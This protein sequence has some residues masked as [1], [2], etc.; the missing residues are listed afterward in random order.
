M[1]EQELKEK[2]ARIIAKYLCKNRYSHFQL[3][4]DKANC[5][6]RENFAECEVIADTVDALITAG[7]TFD[8]T[9]AILAE[10]TNS[11]TLIHKA[12][13]Y[14]EMKHRAAVAERA[15]L[16]ACV[17][18]IKDKEDNVNAELLA[19]MVYTNYLRKAEKELQEDK[20]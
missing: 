5:Y 17:N 15:L 4:G 13:Y 10:R 1:R 19:R 8:K 9:T 12:Q 7:L 20:Q 11:K 16:T 2:I 18:L 6:S 14:D 3:Y